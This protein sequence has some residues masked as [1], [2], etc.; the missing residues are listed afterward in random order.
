MTTAIEAAP[1]HLA[2][3]RLRSAT[4]AMRLTYT[5]FGVRKTLTEPQKAQAAE[6]FGAAGQY[7]S[8]GKKLLDTRHPRFKAVT[9]VRRQATAY[10]QGASLPFPEPAVRLVRQGDLDE[11]QQRMCEFEAVLAAAAAA[12]DDSYDEL[13]AGARDKLGRLYSAADYPDS[14][15]GLFAMSWEFPSVEP[16]D[17]LRRLSP[18]LYR[19][20]CQRVAARFDEAVELAE[21]MFLEELGKLVGHLAERLTGDADGKPKVFRDSAIE[22][23]TEFFGRFQRLNIR[24]SEAVD[25]LVHE[26]RAVISGVR[27]QALRDSSALR[28]EVARELAR[29]SASLDQL[30]VDRPRRNILR[31][32][33]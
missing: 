19:Q 31:R 17:Y 27:P 1:T 6:S 25:E 22:N 13:R 7:L 16:P 15:A 18:E 11:I 21:Q 4:A 10:F 24:S 32:P 29:V 28:G 8:A 12:L 9:A 23:L 30:M 20:E 33:R 2:A 14:L 26:A 3:G 5:W